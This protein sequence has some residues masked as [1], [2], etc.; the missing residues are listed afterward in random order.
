MPNDSKAGMVFT[1]IYADEWANYRMNLPG[2]SMAN[3]DY[4]REY[5][6]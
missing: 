1:H 3:S 4:M 6:R 5:W 2:Y